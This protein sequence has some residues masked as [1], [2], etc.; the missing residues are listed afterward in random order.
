MSADLEMG[1]FGP[2]RWRKD[3]SD[4]E[5]TIFSE[6]L[7]SSLPLMAIHFFGAQYLRKTSKQVAISV[8]IPRSLSFTA[9]LLRNHQPTYIFKL[10]ITYTND[11]SL[12]S[13]L[14]SAKCVIC[15][16][17]LLQLNNK[18]LFSQEFVIYRRKLTMQARPW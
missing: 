5:W 14:L 7:I 10:F 16:T 15:P 3:T 11:G 6:T 9:T 18:L 12:V 17:S 8:N 4:L 13:I 1:W 2:G